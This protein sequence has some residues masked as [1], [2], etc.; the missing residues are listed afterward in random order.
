MI[1]LMAAGGAA[2]L[3]AAFCTPMLIRWLSHRHIRQNIRELGP[4]SHFIKEGTP[5]MGGLAIVASMILG[6]VMGHVGSGLHFTKAGILAVA[7]VCGFG[8]IGFIDD[9]LKVRHRHNLGLNKRAKFTSQVLIALAFGMLAL[10]WAKTDTYLSFT[11][12]SSPGVNL[13]STLWVV[14]VAVI[15]IATAN[16]VNLTDGLD[17]LA[18][19]SAT[20]AFSCLAIIG[21]WQ[22]RHF[23][24]YNVRSA[25]DLAVLSVAFAGACLGF[26]WWNA[27]P[28]KLFMGDT[29]SLA[30]GAGLG[31]LSIELNLQLLLLIIGGLFVV[32]TLSVI[33]QVVSFHL[34]HKRVFKMAPLHHH[35]ELA[36]WQETTVI[37]RFWILAGLC[38]AFGLA[39]FYADFLSVSP[40]K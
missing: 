5:T 8:L 16:A 26:L 33:I 6:Y 19:G 20:F 35:F 4:Q 40:P 9:W 1:G 23:S 13:G 24:I 21:Y 32:V 38:S 17:G 10:H 11:R 18:S 28:A 37:V 7:V 30:I 14:W 25:L 15:I 36:G 31:A 3:V 29:G 27:K 22:F 34:F 39:V 2:L 12:W